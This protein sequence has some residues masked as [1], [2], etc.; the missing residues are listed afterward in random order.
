MKKVKKMIF[1]TT[2]MEN[3]GSYRTTLPSMISK[4]LGAE[5]GKKGKWTLEIDEKGHSKVT[6]EIPEDS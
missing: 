2:I 1:E 4:F 5:K 6:F 3:R